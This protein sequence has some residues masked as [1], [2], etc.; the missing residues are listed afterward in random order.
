MAITENRRVTTQERS[1]VLKRE[2][3][4]SQLATLR[5]LEQ[6]GWQLKF[7]RHDRSRTLAVLFD[8][9]ARHYAL[10]GSDG[11][12]DENPIFEKFR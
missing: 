6:F 12:V 8:P 3:N 7:L 11:N 2:L 10:L 1:A 4:E 5:T 9:D